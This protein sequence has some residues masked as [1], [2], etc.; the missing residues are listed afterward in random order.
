MAAQEL[1]QTMMLTSSVSGSVAV[2]KNTDKVKAL[3]NAKGVLLGEEIDASVVG[4]R[5]TM[6]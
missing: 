2:A 4:F 1:W 5:T 3:F 6:E